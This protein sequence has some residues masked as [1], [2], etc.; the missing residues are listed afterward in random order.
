MAVPPPRRDGRRFVAPRGAAA[1]RAD[2]IA[3]D[4]T[5]QVGRMLMNAM[6]SPLPVA[7]IAGA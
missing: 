7:V 4:G 5:T 6:N 1:Q 2:Q 3:A